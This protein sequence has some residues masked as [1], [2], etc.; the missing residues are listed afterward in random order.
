ML[1][2]CS[3]VRLIAAIE[4]KYNTPTSCQVGKGTSAPLVGDIRRRQV[5]RV[6]SE[7]S[8]EL[9]FNAAPLVGNRVFILAGIVRPLGRRHP[10][11][12][13]RAGGYD[14]EYATKSIAFALRPPTW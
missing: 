12:G 14:M 13:S 7:L 10:R 1:V 6:I 3:T 8:A 2:F 11:N 5:E 4:Q 9:N